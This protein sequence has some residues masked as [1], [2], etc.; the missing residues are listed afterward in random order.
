[1]QLKPVSQLLIFFMNI[2]SD[3]LT[4]TSEQL[5]QLMNSFIDSIPKELK[6]SLHLCV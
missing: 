5:D 6:L 1:M 3:K 4:L 2:L